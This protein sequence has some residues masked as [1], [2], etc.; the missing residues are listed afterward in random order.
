MPP[1]M[2]SYGRLRL[3]TSPLPS[4]LGFGVPAESRVKDLLEHAITTTHL[5]VEVTDVSD[6][7]LY[8]TH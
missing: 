1:S 5:V 3:N 8:S 6:G 2:T 7:G 4:S